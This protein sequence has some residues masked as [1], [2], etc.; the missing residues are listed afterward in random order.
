[1]FGFQTYQ[2]GAGVLVALRATIGD[3]AFFELLRR[4]VA[5]NDG[6]SRTTEDFMALAEEVAG[7]DLQP[8]FDEWLLGVPTPSGTV[9]TTVP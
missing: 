7:K 3:D 4:W 1:M 6:T 8:F 5:D 2:G 9:P